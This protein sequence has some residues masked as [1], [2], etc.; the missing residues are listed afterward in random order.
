MKPT[1]LRPAEILLERGDTIATAESLTGGA[2]CVRLVETEGISA[3]LLGGIVSY[4][5]EMKAR[6]LGVDTTLLDEQGPVCGQVASQMAQGIARVTGAV[7]TVSTTGVAGPGPADGHEQG[8]V[9]IGR[10]DGRAFGFTFPGTRAE[11]SES[12]VI[13]AVHLLADLELPADLA[14]FLTAEETWR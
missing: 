7:H 12:T 11:V 9:W 14:K 5:D 10:E 6:M 2:V 13:A 8:T 3:I 4:T 1:E